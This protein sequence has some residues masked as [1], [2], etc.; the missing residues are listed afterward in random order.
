MNELVGYWASSTETD[1][2]I[3]TWIR[4]FLNN[5]LEESNTGKGTGLSV[6]CIKNKN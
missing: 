5:N 3:M 4:Q 1:A 6:L 2:K